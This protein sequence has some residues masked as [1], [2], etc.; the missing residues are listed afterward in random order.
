MLA[1]ARGQ[2]HLDVL[3]ALHPSLDTAVVYVETPSDDSRVD[4]IFRAG[5]PSLSGILF[6][7]VQWHDG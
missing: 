6:R 2:D 5:S 3:E 4:R 7:M 1:Q